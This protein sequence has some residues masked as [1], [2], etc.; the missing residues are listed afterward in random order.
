MNAYFS[1]DYFTA[2]ERFRD[3]VARANGRLTALAIDATAP[4]ARSLTI[5]VAWFGAERPHRAIVHCSGVH[6]VEGF[7]GSAIQLQ[8]LDR[9]IGPLPDDGA[10]IL[11]H[12]VNPYGMAWRRRVNPRNVDLNRNCL[13]SGHPYVGAPPHYDRLDG[14]V[15]RPGAPG[16]DWFYAR[17][18]YLVCRFGL[19]S[20]RQAIAEGQYVN[21]R[22][23]FFGGAALE[24]EPRL[25]RRLVEDR[26]S[27]VARLTAIDVH[28]G[29][30]QF[31]RDVLLVS[32]AQ[33]SPAFEA[34]RSAY[35]RRITS[36][37]PRRGPAYRARGTF[38]TMFREAVPAARIHF[39]VQEFGTFSAL[40]VFR[41]L[42]MENQ[43]FHAAAH[44]SRGTGEG[45]LADV[46][47]P[48]DAAWQA[49]VL[50]RGGAVV[51]EAVRA[52]GLPDPA[53]GGSGLDG[54]STGGAPS[55][56]L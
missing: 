51:D 6:G 37:D 8:W 35:G 22:G 43:R 24:Q 15:N 31:G 18:A 13:P 30:G 28:T 33:G 39:L 40:K 34:L 42:R 25:V 16:R 17:A 26:L 48:P 9:G 2:R 1:P 10:V 55:M 20:L 4:D 49:A 54:R 29:L 5:D 53:P 38:E 47:S 32:E 36:A 41:A 56:G 23:L 14:F 52:L 45:H 3:A 46:F 27:R 7:A 11:F 44:V 12:V 21:P 50:E 19:V